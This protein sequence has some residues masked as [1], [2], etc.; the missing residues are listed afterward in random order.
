MKLFGVAVQH[1]LLRCSGRLGESFP[2]AAVADCVCFDLVRADGSKVAVT[3]ICENNIV[4]V[5]ALNTGCSGGRS[6]VCCLD[7]VEIEV[8]ISEYCAADGNDCDCAILNAELVNNFRLPLL[9]SSR[10]VSKAV[11]GLSPGL[12]LL[13]CSAAYAPFTPSKSG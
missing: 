8:F 9:K 10:A 12:S 4:G 7:G 13:T 11:P 5:G 2:I 6:S 3:L 1:I